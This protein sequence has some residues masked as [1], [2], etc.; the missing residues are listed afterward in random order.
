MLDQQPS[1][2]DDSW[3]DV[4]LGRTTLGQL[5]TYFDDDQMLVL[6]EA[7]L[8]REYILARET[9]ALA[10]DSFDVECSKVKLVELLKGNGFL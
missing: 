1:S 2:I 8:L 6:E 7:W 3:V 10:V 9:K 5:D 4:L